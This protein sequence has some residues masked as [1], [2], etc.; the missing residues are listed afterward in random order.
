[1]GA[2][3]V[4]QTQW[5]LHSLHPETLSTAVVLESSKHEGW[6]TSSI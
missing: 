5:K 1:M 6:H 2:W 3:I 4:E